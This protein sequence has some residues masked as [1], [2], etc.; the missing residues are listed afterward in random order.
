MERDR[1]AFD[2]PP[3]LIGNFHYQWT[4]IVR[5][6][7]VYGAFSLNYLEMQHRHL[8]DSQM[9]NRPNQG[10]RG[11]NEFHCAGIVER[12]IRLS[13]QNYRPLKRI[14]PGRDP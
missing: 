12:S 9:R 11:Q 13:H 2:R 1:C 14:L 7:G 3:S 8:G 5:T 4:R 10:C 6:G